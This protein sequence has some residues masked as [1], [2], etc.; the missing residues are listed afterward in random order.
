M[1]TE[2]TTYTLSTENE[3]NLFD[4]INEQMYEDTLKQVSISFGVDALGN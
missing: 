3:P 2:N 4:F 1:E